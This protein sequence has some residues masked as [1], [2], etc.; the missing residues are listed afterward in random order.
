MN[1]FGTI[2]NPTQ[3][4]PGSWLKVPYSGPN[5]AR[6]HLKLQK[7]SKYGQPPENLVHPAFFD[8]DST[9]S[10]VQIRTPKQVQGEYTLSAAVNDEWFKVGRIIVDKE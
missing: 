4:T 5:P 9:G 8:Q 7:A 3:T 2:P 10:Y 1:P 6:L